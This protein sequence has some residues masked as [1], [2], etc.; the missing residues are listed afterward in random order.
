MTNEITSG[1]M[2]FDGSAPLTANWGSMRAPLERFELYVP[3]KPVGYLVIGG[4]Y[5]VAIYKKPTPEQIKNHL[6][7]LGWEWEDVV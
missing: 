4:S 3:P 5:K 2:T 7:M 1:S 6:E